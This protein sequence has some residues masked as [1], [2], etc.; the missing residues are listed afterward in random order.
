MFSLDPFSPVGELSIAKDSKGPGRL[1]IHPRTSCSG[2]DMWSCG[3]PGAVRGCQTVTLASSQAQC[4]SSCI[5]VHHST[6]MSTSQ[7]AG[8]SIL[9]SIAIWTSLVRDVVWLFGRKTQ[10][11]FLGEGAMSISLWWPTPAGNAF[12]ANVSMHLHKGHMHFV[13]VVVF[14]GM[15]ESTLPK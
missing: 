9:K 7:F 12:R 11:A 15:C 14:G 5:P 13:V 1:G 8:C 6:R 4:G 3:T 10:P 2:R